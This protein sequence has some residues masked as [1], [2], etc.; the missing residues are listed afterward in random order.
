MQICVYFQEDFKTLGIPSSADAAGARD[1]F[2]KLAKKYHPDSGHPAA[3]E[4]KF[5]Q[6]F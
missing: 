5:K 6:V 4:G 1:A 2:I 3:D